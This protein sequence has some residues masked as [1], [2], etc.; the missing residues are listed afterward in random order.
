MVTFRIG[1]RNLARNKR[2]AIITIGAMS[3]AL[4]VM[5]IY[6]GLMMG[7]LETFEKNAIAMDL[8]SIQ[9]HA[10]EY[11]NDPSIYHWIK[12]SDDIIERLEKNGFQASSRRY[13]F[14]LAAAGMSSAG[15]QLRGTD[16]EGEPD[17]T[18]LYKHVEKGLWL[19]KDHPKEVVIGKKLAK[20]L[21]V[22]LNDEIVL[23]GQAADGSM[24][25]DL[26]YV[27][28]ILKS[29]S[30]NIDRTGFFMTKDA[31]DTLMVYS[32][33]A[34]EIAIKPP[35]GMTLDQAVSKVKSI[36]PNT[37]VLSWRELA[38]ALAQLIDMSDVSLYLFYIIAYAAIGMVILN[39]MLMAVFERI[40][41]YGIMKALGVS[42][43]Q[44]G[45]MVIIETLVQTIIAALIGTGVG[46]PAALYLQTHGIDLTIFG[47]GT[48][49]AGIAMDTTWKTV[50]TSSTVTGPIVFMV[51]MV[52]IAVIYP[53][54]K[55]AMVQPLKAIY[56]R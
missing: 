2:R 14:A 54:I 1:A 20:T 39:A 29:V 5:I 28:G 51:L 40:R 16:V 42:P 24:A 10:P 13:G 18:Q 32:G 53:G 7:F 36:A 22:T 21:N 12:H 15:V 45:L 6:A 47:S 56:H 50:V 23:L 8:S 52:S 48:S 9:I 4:A 17:V 30:E 46:L 26:Y 33:G 34:H 37:E 27:R 55:A 49:I 38:P 44:I 43:S 19:D 35:Q 41:E 11:R 3:F 25:N 31:Y